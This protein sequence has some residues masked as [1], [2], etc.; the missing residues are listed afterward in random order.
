MELQSLQPLAQQL[1]ADIRALT[2]DG[3][4]VTRASYGAGENA[5]ARHLEAFARAEGLEVTTDRAGNFIYSDPADT[6]QGPVIW[7]GSHLDSVPQGGNYDGLA[8]IVA[9]L[10]V[11]IAAKR[12]GVTLPAPLQVIGFRG[13]ESAWFGKAYMGSGALWGKLTAADLALQRRE[14][15]VTLGDALAAC[16]ADLAAIARQDKL[17]NPADIRAYVELH[18]EQGPVM[19]AR[20]I[21]VGVVSGIRGNVRHN[22]IECFG[23]AQHSGVV[24]RWLRKDAVFAVSDLIV[25]LDTHWRALLERGTDLVVTCG[26][27]QTNPA[28]H[29]ISRVP[30][31]AHFSFEARSKSSD[32]LEAFYQLVQAEMASIERERGVKFQLD[33]R[34][35]S[36]PAVTDPQLCDLMAK[37]CRERGIAHERIPSGAGH[38]AALFANG[39][40]PSAM[41]FVRNQHG[42]HNPHEAMELSDF[43]LGTQVMADTIA[44]IPVA[45]ASV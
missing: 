41:V 29:S 28:E 6:R 23:E 5:C 26:V 17:F 44:A 24:P 38:D 32:T 35:L 3:V 13:E 8:G 33:R 9:G 27:V 11:L 30:G 40:V 45:P 15:G 7:T 43:M 36:E 25:R 20:E 12:Q 21:P 22:K 19:V 1:F 4:G 42:S 37:A 39:G 2:F 31:Y 16:G 18:I 14:D 34:L 10:L